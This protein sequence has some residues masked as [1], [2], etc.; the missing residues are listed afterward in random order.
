MAVSSPLL[1]DVSIAGA[2]A[3]L[4]NICGGPGL[5]LHEVHE[6]NSIIVES[7][8]EEANVIFGA[9]IDPDMGDEIRI[10][11]IA[12]GF[13][14]HE[15]IVVPLSIRE[16][17]LGPSSRLNRR[18]PMQVPVEV[19]TSSS[20]APAVAP[21][22]R[23]EQN[24]NAYSDA[25]VGALHMIEDED[26]ETRRIRE[27]QDVAFRAVRKNLRPVAHGHADVA[28]KSEPDPELVAAG[29]VESAE[30]QAIVGAPIPVH[31]ESVVH[32]VPVETRV[33]MAAPVTEPVRMSEPVAM[34]EPAT[35]PVVAQHVTTEAPAGEEGAHVTEPVVPRQSRPARDR[36]N[37]MSY[38]RD[39][40]EVPAFIRR[41][42]D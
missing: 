16:P 19:Y 40:L 38:T 36:W 10:T 23:A 6:A 25:P 15:E 20:A 7:A 41:Q 5:S 35:A 30:P 1:E 29:Q 27:A 33:P 37:Y 2:E 13:G 12:T 39:N 42:M 11:V 18:P 9:V 24:A 21:V 32:H 28:R 34:T 26:V 22:S 17:H 4:V 31:H 14:R 3:L 8:G